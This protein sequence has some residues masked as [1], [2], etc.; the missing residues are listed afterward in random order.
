MNGRQVG[1]AARALRP[2]LKVL[3]ITGYAES[4]VLDATQLA[5]GMQLLTKPFAL[6]GLVERIEALLS[7]KPWGRMDAVPEN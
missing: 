3:F 5:P 4:N 7:P 6:Q 1:E 2:D